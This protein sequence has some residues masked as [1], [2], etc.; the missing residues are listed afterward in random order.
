MD[1]RKLL[2]LASIIEHGSFK[3]AAKHLSLSQPALSTSMDRLEESIGDKLLN[4]GPSGITPTALGELVYSHARLIRDEIDLA[5]K[6]IRSGEPAKLDPISLGT[7]PSLASHVVPMA[8]C[9]WR[10]RHPTRV[11]RVLTINQLDLTLHLIRGELDFIIGMTDFY[12]H[13]EGLRQR[14][15]FR[16]RLYVIAR[17]GHPAFEMPEL[18]W[19]KL[20]E[21]PWILQMFGRHR[22]LLETLLKAED[23]V[24]PQQLTE[25]GSVDFIK[26]LV[27]ESDS[28]ALLPGHAAATDIANGRLK[29]LN[30]GA[31]QLGRDIAVVFREWSPLQPAALELVSEVE[32]AGL[33]LSQRDGPPESA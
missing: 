23:A 14:V 8:L 20:T 18:C 30:L 2:Y 4:R 12:G 21:F 25:C 29:R 9:K 19:A 16:D 24:L 10:E 15:L 6:R 27:A 3:R 33:L 1:P 17:P 28:L 13:L 11:L 5:A 22:T 31:A 32:A 7:L 26:S